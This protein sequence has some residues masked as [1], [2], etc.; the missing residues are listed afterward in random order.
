MERI[1][2]WFINVRRETHAVM[3]HSSRFTPQASAGSSN[4]HAN[5]IIVSSKRVCVVSFTRS[6]RRHHRRHTF[7]YPVRLAHLHR[8]RR[9]SQTASHLSLA[10]P[11]WKSPLNLLHIAQGLSVVGR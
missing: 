6:I 4:T 11:G 3:A 2:A 7:Q 5:V 8:L 9:Q 1:D 10:F